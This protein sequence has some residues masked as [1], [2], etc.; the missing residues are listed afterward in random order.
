M[1]YFFTSAINIFITII[2]LCT[3]IN[4]VKAQSGASKKILRLEDV[5]LWRNSSVSLSDDGN[6]Y[7]VIYSLTEKP[8]KEDGDAAKDSVD[9]ALYGKD[10]RTDVLYIYNTKSGLKYKIP[11]GTNPVF[12]SSSRWIAYRRAKDEKAE[13][14]KE[15][16]KAK[17]AEKENSKG[18]IVLRNLYTGDSIQYMSDAE[19]RFA[20]DRD[21]FLTSDDNS[22]SIYDLNNRSEHYTGNTGEYITADKKSDL[23][24]YTISSDDKRGN[25]IYLY[26]PE[27]MTTRALITGNYVFSNLSWNNDR[28]SIAALRYNNINDNVDIAGMAIV[29]ISDI[30]SKKVRYSEYTVKDIEGMPENMAPAVRTAQL[31]NEITWSNDDERLFIKIKEYDSEQNKD[32]AKEKKK[33]EEESTVNVWHWKDK[34][35]LSQRM[36]EEQRNEN[37]VYDA[38]FILKSDKLIQLTG[39]EQRLIRS[40]GTDKW[41][42]CADNGK[43]VSDWDVRKYDLYKVN[44]TTGDRQLIAEEY[45]GSIEMSPDGEKIIL[46][47]DGHYWYYDLKTDAMENITAGMDIS[48]IDDENDHYGYVPDYGFTG[49][50]KDRNAVIVSHKLDMWLIPLNNKTEAVNLTSSANGKDEIRFRLDDNSFKRE[51]QPEDRYIDLNTDI[52]LSAFSLK[53]K[54]AG[55]YKLSNNTLKK[56]IY[57]PAS[58]GNS[59]W[60]SGLLKAKKSDVIIYKKGDYINYPESYL[61]DLSFSDSKKIT[62]T[63]PQQDDYIWGTR[64]LFDYTNDDGVPLQGTLSIPDSYSKGR[65]L[66]VVV[67]SYEKLSQDM[68]QYPQPSLSGSSICE[69]MYVSDGYLVLHPDI[70]FN[71]GTPH[72]D[73]HECID[74]AIKKV[75]ELGYADKDRIG[76]E[77]FSFGGHCGMYMSTQKNRFAAIAAGAGVSNLVQGFDIDIVRDGSNEQDYYITG[78]GRL[79]TDPTSNTDMFIRESAVF[80]AANMNTP[81]MLFHGTADNVVQWEH[82]FG[83]YN[84]LRYLKKPVVFLS[85]QGEGHGLRKKSNRIDIQTRLKEYFDHYLKGKEAADWMIQEIPYMPKDED[86]EKEKRTVPPWK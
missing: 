68:Y 82:S 2:L 52:I 6:W 41:A 34:K 67:Y 78:Q 44:L 83:F 9:Q 85:Y 29:V 46:W 63:N 76:Y 14:A 28:S 58:F 60:S 3:G 81:L 51:D 18:A 49:W 27:D 65:K 47:K 73:M 71:I 32:N 30:N 8:E 77:G 31:P 33:S 55:Y 21:Y 61:S 74:A 38:L 64:I 54:Y 56:L 16:G 66:P 37:V 57:E 84:I 39:E 25:G 59:V 86:K 72:S 70:H 7:T 35:L 26:N 19:Y 17:K 24:I 12:S 11:K 1:K 43:Y 42:V 62:N 13:E 80:N 79:G 10:A 40:R 22:L 15:A 36:I 50:V 5:E 23:F 48:F 4:D 45:A 75:I 20:E 69:M 53:T